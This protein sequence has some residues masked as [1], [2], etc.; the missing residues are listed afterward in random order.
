MKKLC[1]KFCTASLFISSIFVIPMLSS[2]K[3]KIKESEQTT[4]SVTEE[5]DFEIPEHID[6]L[7][8]QLLPS[9]VLSPN[10]GLNVLGRDKQMHKM[11]SLSRGNAFETVQVNGAVITLNLYDEKE[12]AETYVHAVSENVDFWI[13]KNY[14]AENALPAIIIEETAGFKFGQI[15][16]LGL[17]K[18]EGDD[19]A[20][21]DKTKALVYYFDKKQDKVCSI[22]MDQAK[23]ST[24]KD[25]VEMAAII[26]K[27]RVTARATPR[28]ELFLRAE[29]LNAS[30][31]MK[32]VLE[33]EKTEKLSY[34]Y[35][36]VLKSMPGSRYI[37]NVGELNTVDQS[38][39]PFKD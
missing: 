3:G 11:K 10:A 36:E 27:L 7:E 8:E 34:D 22:L 21:E 13:Y 18:V 14:V 28:N 6:L 4:Q 29:K 32:K 5:S 39:D 24:C 23:V 25:D 31:A 12:N 35:Q 30:P 1:Q 16:A 9:V 2:C 17:D 20:E 19:A 33:G 37:V 15:V 38:K 26:E